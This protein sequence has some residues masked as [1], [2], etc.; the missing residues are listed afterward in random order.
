MNISSL[1]L[2]R[3][4]AHNMARLKI[5]RKITNPPIV[6]GFKP[7]GPDIDSKKR[8]SIILNFEEYEAFRMCDYNMYNH[9]QASVLMNVSRP[10]FTRIYASARMK[11][12][13]A[14]VE[15]RQ[16]EFEGG[17]VYF[18]SD[19]YQCNSCGCHFNNPEISISIQ[20]CPLCGSSEV[21]RHT[22]ESLG[23]MPRN[24]ED[25]LCICPECGFTKEHHYGVPCRN[26]KC[27]TCN[28]P[29]IR[30]YH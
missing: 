28:S 26:E 17:K 10:T 13:K 20:N 7:Y 5:P 23:D 22:E 8:E 3:T 25:D 16:I 14:F 2:Y 27:P 19:W 29:L 12:S 21:E 24:S 9:Y 6:K 1:F 11:I 4:I 15:G 18:D 30:K